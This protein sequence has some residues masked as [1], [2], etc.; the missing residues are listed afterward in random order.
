MAQDTTR[1]S[2]AEVMQALAAELRPVL[3]GSLQ[4]MYVYLDDAHKLC[5]P[6]FASML[7]YDSPADWD[8]PASFTEQ[9]VDPG[10]Q[11]TLVAA[12]RDA[13]QHQVAATIDV[14]WKRRDGGAVST[15]VILV[16]IAHSGELMALHFVT[17]Q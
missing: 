5:N 11:H 8:R 10:S 16:P 1:R 3:D 15:S 7:G 9:Y 2:R 17:P 14:T 12:Y 6:R 4:G 13:M